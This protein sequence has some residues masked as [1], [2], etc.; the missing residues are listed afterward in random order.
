MVCVFLFPLTLHALSFE[1][2]YSTDPGSHPGL[3]KYDVKFYWIDL[4]VTDTSTYLEGNTRILIQL[5]ES[6]MDT[7]ILELVDELSIDSIECEDQN[8]E[9]THQNDLIHIVLSKDYLKDD[10][11]M[12]KVNYHGI[13]GNSSG[14][15]TG[16]SSQMDYTYQTDVTWT[17]SEP[18]KAKEWFPCKQVLDDKADSA[19]VFLTVDSRL[20]AG[21][22]GVLTQVVEL[23]NNKKRYEWKTYHKIAYYLISLAVAEYDEYNIYAKPYGYTDSILIQNYIYSKNDYLKINKADIDESKDI[24]E[25]YSSVYGIYPFADEKYGHCLAP[26]G[27]GMEHQ[28]MTTLSNMDFLLV[29]HEM[30]HQWFGDYITCASWNDIWVNEGFASYSEYLSLQGLKD[31]VQADKWMIQ[32]HNYAMNNNNRSIYVPDDE[33]GDEYRV[34]DY[35]IT[36]KKGA[37]II[38]M[39]RYELNNDEIFFN[40]LRTIL[41]RYANNVVSAEQV[42]ALLEELSGKDFTTFF[43]QWYY[44][45]GYPIY[46]IL[47]CYENDTFTIC[48]S[49]EPSNSNITKFVHDFDLKLSFADGDTTIRLHQNEKVE[50]FKILLKN[51][52]FSVLF[53]PENWLLK[54]L[55]S[56]QNAKDTL[57]D[58]S[59]VNVSPNPFKKQLAVIYNNPNSRGV[60]L[61]IRDINGKVVY[62]EYSSY[63]EFYINTSSFKPGVY[64]LELVEGSRRHTQK[65]IRK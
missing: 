23:Q 31:Q 33:L 6:N 38:H 62:S 42:K 43:D 45:M 55:N 2:N 21:S 54:E 40:F 34:F 47:W 44:G 14:F 58:T 57:F 46:D 28:T 10:L 60:K 63:P 24:L 35:S 9:F 51:R 29:T 37:A 39:I 25:Y 15:F 50:T 64:I 27:G 20:K 56:L 16:I 48:L 41:T 52:V 4:Q 59:L 26:M 36:Y 61:T 3:H 1:N 30:S 19:Y 7:V 8:L 12:L 32:A 49:Q 13:G 53:D 17:L 18:L 5:L 22:N 11:L 65:I